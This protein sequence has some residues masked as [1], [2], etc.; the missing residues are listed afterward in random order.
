MNSAEVSG[1]INEYENKEHVAEALVL[2]CRRRW[3][4][5]ND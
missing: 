1:F 3:D 5:M 2:E 4:E